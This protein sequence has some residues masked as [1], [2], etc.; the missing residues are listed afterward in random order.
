MR[1]WEGGGGEEGRKGEGEEEEEGGRR[2]LRDLVLRM[3]W[4]VFLFV[5][6]L[7]YFLFLFLFFTL[8]L[9]DYSNPFSRP[10]PKKRLLR[11]AY[12][13]HWSHLNSFDAIPLNTILYMIL[14]WVYQGISHELKIDKKSG[15]R[16]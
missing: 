11:H 7:F 16:V 3:G 12:K 9:Y 4:F 15:D 1:K 2:V 10:P 5:F 14:H 8:F 13:C 6:N